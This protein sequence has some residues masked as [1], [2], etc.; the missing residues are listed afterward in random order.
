MKVILKINSNL[1]GM[2]WVYNQLGQ[3]VTTWYKYQIPSI[4]VGAIY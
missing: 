3:Q 2:L 4:K 1:S